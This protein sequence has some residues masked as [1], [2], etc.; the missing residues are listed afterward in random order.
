MKDISIHTDSCKWQGKIE[1]FRNKE[2]GPVFSG[3]ITGFAL[4]RYDEYFLVQYCPG[5]GTKLIPK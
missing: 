1:Y 5:C 3:A 4:R 2:I